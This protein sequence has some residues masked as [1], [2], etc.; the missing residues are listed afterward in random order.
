MVEE[1]ISAETGVGPAMASGSHVW[2][3]NW[4]DLPMTAMNSATPAQSRT[5]LLA[6]PNSAQPEMAKIEKPS[7]PRCSWAPRVRAEEQDRYADEQADV[8]H[9]HGEERLQA[10]RAFA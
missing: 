2:S 3:G 9:A 5:V 1:C 7:L 6:S 4:P 10:A 8:A